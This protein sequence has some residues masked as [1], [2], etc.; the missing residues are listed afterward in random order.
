MCDRTTPRTRFCPPGLAP[1]CV[2]RRSPP[3]T[4][5]HD[6]FTTPKTAHARTTLP[7]PLPHP[8][9][10]LRRTTLPRHAT[11]LSSSRRA[12]RCTL[13]PA[14]HPPRSLLPAPLPPPDGASS[15]HAARRCS[16]SSRPPPA[17]VANPGTNS[18][19][20]PSSNSSLQYPFPF[21]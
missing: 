16:C 13:L 21:F 11:P 15:S 14:P 6:G 1:V 17:P 20:P 3:P 4:H 19:S 7:S 10:S 8:D 5:S 12:R 18:S 2:A 9:E